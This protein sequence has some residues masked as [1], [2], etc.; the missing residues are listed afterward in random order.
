[1]D[2]QLKFKNRRAMIEDIA[3]AQMDMLAF[4]EKYKLSPDQLAAWVKDVKNHQCL[5]SLCL[6]ADLQT[7]LLLSRYRSLAANKLIHLATDEESKGDIARRACVDLLKLDLKRADIDLSD[8]GVGDS[9]EKS[10]AG[11]EQLRELLYKDGDKPV[12]KKR[13]SK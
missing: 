8:L 10:S 13:K 12:V 6:L 7:Q 1:M 4:A 3:I 9:S 11:I 5:S 2:R